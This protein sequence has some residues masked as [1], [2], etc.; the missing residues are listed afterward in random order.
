MKT[1]R[2]LLAALL[3]L[4]LAPA[5]RANIYFD[6]AVASNG[7]A[8]QRVSAY[9]GQAEKLTSN[10][11]FSAWIY[12]TEGGSYTA[13]NVPVAL[14]TALVGGSSIIDSAEILLTASGG[15][16]RLELARGGSY[17]GSQSTVAVP[18]NQWTHVAVT[19][20]STKV[21]SYY[22]NGAAAGVFPTQYASRDVTLG[23]TSSI[24]GGRPIFFMGNM[25]GRKFKGRMDEVQIW[26][27]ALTQTQIQDYLHTPPVGNEAALADWF[28]FDD[29]SQGTTAANSDTVNSSGAASLQGGV[30]WGLGASLRLVVTTTGDTGEGS[31]RQAL[32]NAVATPGADTIAFDYTLDGQTIALASELIIN[33]PGGVTVDGLQRSSGI[34]VNGNAHRLFTTTAGQSVTLHGLTLAGGNGLGA[35]SSGAGGA[36]LN[37][38]TLTLD[39]CVLA[40]NSAGTLR[41]GAVDNLGTLNMSDST[42]SGSTAALEGGGVCNEAGHTFTADR[43]TFSGNTSN[44]AVNQPGG[45]ALRNAGSA[46][47]TNCTFTGN[48][49]R[50]G[51]GIDQAGTGTLA[52]VHCT[53][54]GNTATQ[55]SGGGG[56]RTLRS[57]DLTNSIIAGNTGPGSSP[58]DVQN[59]GVSLVLHGPSILPSLTNVNGGS[60]NTTAGSLITTAPSLAALGSYGGPTPTRPLLPGSV[61]LDTPGIATTGLATDQRGVPR[62]LDG[63]GDGTASADLGAVELVSM[64]FVVVTASDTG[65]GSLREA[66]TAVALSAGANTIAFAPALSGQT[67]TFGST[68]YVNDA[69]GVT[70]DASGLPGGLT[71][72]SSGATNHFYIY[73][74]ASLTLQNLTLTGGRGGQG[75]SIYNSGTLTLTHCTFFGNVSDSDGGA[76]YNG[77]VLALTHCTFSGNACGSFGHGGAIYDYK[78]LTSTHCTFSGNSAP[79]NG[80]GGAIYKDA[81]S[82]VL[83]LT[84]TIAAGNTP[85]N[86][87]GTFTGTTNLT[88]GNPLLAPLG[89]YGGPTKTMALLPGSPARDAA[90]VLAPAITA[91]QR[92]FPIV[93][94]PDIGAYEAGTLASFAAW[95]WE[96]AGSALAFGT[97]TDA[98]S[99]PNGLEYALRSNPSVP[100]APLFPAPALVTLTGNVPA[101]SFTFPYRPEAT[102]LRYLLQRNT[103]LANA[104]GWATVLT[105]DLAT[106]TTTPTS[107]VAVTL[108]APSASA[109][110]TDTNLT[111]PQTFW[112]LRVQPAP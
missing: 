105:F 40:G 3:A 10:Y 54:A 107:G 109:T 67:I 15:T 24:P 16:Q 57:W 76:L 55:A 88:T 60:P 100:N 39:R 52:L 61:G 37:L 101:A 32:A 47:L 41:G 110:I 69:D 87:T 68:I 82:G 65:P 38:G 99:A 70:V 84:N 85:N 12:P 92:G 48:T 53:I 91:D 94:P 103:D 102:D 78:T 90:A 77:G 98:D 27:T 19:V 5:L 34:I 21:V 64:P 50:Y 28:R 112:R 22:I 11:T 25:S 111:A 17:T 62:A 106:H 23:G 96:T 73:Y 42:V 56:L 36:I 75:G 44:N 35:T 72:S 108:D 4:A 104:N 13:P 2:L 95:S 71:L 18:L 80:S 29:F 43:C 58:D 6:D 89:D 93:G 8:G 74:Y 79:S 59:D 66:F 33:D 7:T 31:L 63:D 26:S 9:I 83:T 49:A 46:T 81:T 30:T 51:G 86:I 14:L 45:G 97:D 1:T 20:S